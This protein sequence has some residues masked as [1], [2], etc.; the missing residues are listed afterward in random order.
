MKTI[1]NY[2]S[3]LCIIM[4]VAIL[5]PVR[6]GGTEYKFQKDLHITELKSNGQVGKASY[7]SDYYDGKKTASGKTFRQSEYTCAHMTLP[8]GTKIKVTNLANSKEVIVTVTDRGNFPKGRVVD[9]S[10]KAFGEIASLK[11]GL[12]N[13]KIEII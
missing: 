6:A 9:L 13:V 12:V 1:K 4:S 11:S 2:L 7:Y 8:F 5:S 10:K 3:T